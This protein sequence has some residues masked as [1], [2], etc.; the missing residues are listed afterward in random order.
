MLYH[1]S[2]K[3]V[4][5]VEEQVKRSIFSGTSNLWAN[6]TEISGNSGQSEKK[7]IPRKV[8]PFFRKHFTG[9]NRSI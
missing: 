3:R 6:G 8:L 1:L 7:G 5:L 4:V 2:E 9:M